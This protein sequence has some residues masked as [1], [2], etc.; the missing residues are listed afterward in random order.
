MSF[1]E[2]VS[3]KLPLIC[4]SR[5]PKAGLVRLTLLLTLWLLISFPAFG[6]SDLKEPDAA[7]SG[8]RTYTSRNFL[9]HTD[10]EPEA[11]EELIARLEIMLGSISKYWGQPNQSTIECFVV[12][13]L[14]QWPHGAIPPEA[15]PSIRQ[16]AGVSYFRSVPNNPQWGTKAQVFAVST[17]GV[18]QHEAVHAYCSQTFGSTGPVWYA[19]G[20]AE[21]GNYWKDG[22][23]SVNASPKVID[24]LKKSAPKSLNEIINGGEI[25]GDS[26][27]NYAW[28]WA[29]CHLLAHN[30]N[31]Q[32]RFRPLGL[33]LLQ[34][35]QT[36][37]EDVYGSMDDE[38]VFEY[39]QFLKHL[40]PGYRVDLCSWNWKA[41]PRLVQTRLAKTKIKARSGWQPTRAKIQKGE[42]YRFA[43]EGSWQLHKDGPSINA[44]GDESGHGQLVGAVFQDYQLSEEFEIGAT[45][46]FVSP[47]EGHLFVRCKEG[48]GT[49]S[50]NDGQIDFQI[51]ALQPVGT[52]RPAARK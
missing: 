41:R 14:K 37:F 3:R 23:V 35:Q 36:S 4:L 27:D 39:L 1:T 5:L 40:Q 26:R 8:P 49:L 21:M 16:R 7:H 10:M 38:I 13:E 22:D 17:R 19:E 45:G 51:R 30:K 28:R 47:A 50:D 33:A 34:K 18:A 43:T 44:G 46:T 20:M 29:L 12:Q 2:P 48:W 25:S 6:Q 32:R 42:S 52:V 24:F 11:V 9:I 31:Y 15:L